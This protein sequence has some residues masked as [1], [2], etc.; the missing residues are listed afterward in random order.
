[1]TPLAPLLF[2]RARVLV[3]APRFLVLKDAQKRKMHW[4]R[5][6]QEVFHGGCWSR[7]GRGRRGEVVLMMPLMFCSCFLVIDVMR[8]SN[9]RSRR[10]EQFL[11]LLGSVCDVYSITV[12]SWLWRSRWT[13]AMFFAQTRLAS[14]VLEGLTVGFQDGRDLQV[15]NG[16]LQS[17][18]FECSSHAH[19]LLL[20]KGSRDLS[21]TERSKYPGRSHQ[22]AWPINGK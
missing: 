21:L 10:T 22:C 17:A 13:D 2:A 11:R 19:V 4:V 16:I 12:Q 14:K 8:F 6:V 5:C 9:W 18:A 15:H 20:V 1:M 3:A 7:G